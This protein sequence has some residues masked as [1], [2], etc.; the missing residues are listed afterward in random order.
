M[1]ETLRIDIE[2]YIHEYLNIALDIFPVENIIS[3]S[4]VEKLLTVAR[5]RQRF[6]LRPLESVIKRL[7][8]KH[9]GD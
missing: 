4:V 5:G 6:D 9:L 2:T 3:E 1:L 8:M 7:V